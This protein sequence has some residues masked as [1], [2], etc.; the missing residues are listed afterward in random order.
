MNT[1]ME[2]IDAIYK[3]KNNIY[4]IIDMIGQKPKEIIENNINELPLQF[5]LFSYGSNSI[6]QLTDRFSANSDNDPYNYL[7]TKEIIRTKLENN[8]KPAKVHGWIRKFFGHTSV[9]GNWQGSSVATIEKITGEKVVGLAIKINKSI[10]NKFTI[11]NQQINFAR[12]ALTNE[13][14]G[15]KYILQLVKVHNDNVPIYAFVRNP[16]YNEETKP[17]LDVYLIAICK[18]LRDYRKKLFENESQSSLNE[19]LAKPYFI[20]RKYVNLGGSTL[21][22]PHKKRKIILP[23]N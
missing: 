13:S 5:W 18:M 9:T 3:R 10:D 17:V 19:E 7:N 20:T 21:Q 1:L 2:N 11:D 23:L 16:L 14:L 12:F 15:N 6:E 4:K 22:N 8:Y